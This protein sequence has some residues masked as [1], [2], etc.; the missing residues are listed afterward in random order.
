MKLNFEN[1]SNADMAWLMN[2]VVSNLNNEDCCFGWLTYWPD[3]ASKS[4]C[5]AYFEDQE[6][7]NE[8]AKTFIEICCDYLCDSDRYIKLEAESKIYINEYMDYG[9]GLY[10]YKQS[11]SDTQTILDFLQWLGFPMKKTNP[12]K[13]NSELYELDKKAYRLQSYKRFFIWWK[14]LSNKQQIC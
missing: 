9:G 14:E 3:G 6:N 4:D 2:Q 13:N 11:P 10:L 1:L 12:E 8:L 7:F 5:V